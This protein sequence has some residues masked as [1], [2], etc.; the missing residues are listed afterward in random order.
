MA[1]SM[2]GYGRGEQ[3][4]TTRRYLVEIKSVNNRFCDISV[5]M[6]RGYAVLENKIREKITERLVRGKI[7]VFVT[8]EDV[9][10][11]NSTVEMNTGLAKA[12]SDAIK[13]IAELTGREDNT[14]AYQIAR[15][16]DVLVARANSLTPE[17]AGA[18]LLP[19]LDAAIEDILKM[20]GIEGEKLVTDLLEK[21][22]AFESMHAA[23]KLRA[24]LV[25]K[26]YK[27]RLMARIE[28]L[29]EEK[30]NLVYDETRRE[31]E[32]AVFA[33]KCAIDEELTR[34]SSHMNQLRET[35]RATGSIGKRLDFI[36]QEMNREV[37]TIG[38]K[39]ND[40][41]ITNYVLDMK[42]ELEK[43]REQIQ[44]LA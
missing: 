36:L 13:T 32:V 1:F 28:D 2:T 41:T 42:T 8:I 44:N 33:D 7:D 16:P 17:E 14:D 22:N 24:P 23:V 34:L 27:E 3:T 29:L 11:G 4:Y 21:V 18:E 40:I 10:D 31:A 15:I 37:N 38:S 30:A 20:R 43:I 39:A 6:P 19:V 9:G 35:L 12:Y 25:P 5:R 26:E